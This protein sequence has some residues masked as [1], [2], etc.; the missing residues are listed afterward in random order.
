MALVAA[1]FALGCAALADGALQYRA[2]PPLFVQKYVASMAHAPFPAVAICSNK[3]ISRAALRNLTRHLHTYAAPSVLTHHSQSPPHSSLLHSSS[4][5]S[6]WE[7]TDDNVIITAKY[8]L[9]V[10]WPER[11]QC[12]CVG[13]II[14]RL[15]II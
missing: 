3:V 2:R 9:Y 6:G 5:R 13:A 7:R 12:Q 4:T 15:V 8:K 10:P 1:T 14:P 11:E